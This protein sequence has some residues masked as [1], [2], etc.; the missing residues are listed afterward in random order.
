[1]TYTNKQWL[2][3]KRPRGMPGDECWKLNEVETLPLKK[4]EVLIKVLYYP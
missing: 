4:G 1:M 2:L 3:D